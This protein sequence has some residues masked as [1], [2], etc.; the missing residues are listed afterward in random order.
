MD[1]IRQ[2][3]ILLGLISFLVISCNNPFGPPG[4][5]EFELTAE[6]YE[7]ANLIALCLSGEITAPD[8]LSHRVLDDLASIRSEFGDMFES[9]QRIRFSPPWVPGCLLVGFDSATAQKVASGEY[10]DWDELNQKYQVKE[11]NTSS[12]RNNWV[13]I[14]FK[15][16]L[17]PRRLSELYEVL[18]G[19]RY[20][21]PNGIGGDFS[22][23]YPR[24]TLA[25]GM[26]YLF[27]E[28]WGDCPSGCIYNQYWYFPIYAFNPLIIRYWNPDE[29]PKAPSWWDEAKQNIELYHSW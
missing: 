29:D 28:G 14:Y 6:D 10:H 3:A 17:H 8:D 13:V 27:R 24:E 11:I 26:T 25:H 4:G 19:V 20:A 21:E 12:I 9:L 16:K 5:R 7:E 18:P 15:D 23:I 2:L 1:K 22:N